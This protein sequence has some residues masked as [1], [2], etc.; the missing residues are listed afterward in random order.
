MGLALEPARSSNMIVGFSLRGSGDARF[1]SLVSIVLTWC[2][3]TPL[4]FVLGLRFGLGLVGVWLAMIVD[5]ASRGL[6][7]YGRWRTGIWRT[8]GVLAREPV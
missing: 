8:K 7:N 2:V 1:T 6:M 4:A 5:E 3:A